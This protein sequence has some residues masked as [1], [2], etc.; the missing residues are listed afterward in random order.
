[1]S[2]NRNSRAIV[3][4]VQYACLHTL[5]VLQTSSDYLICALN[6]RMENLTIYTLFTD[7][8]LRRCATEIAPLAI[9]IRQVKA[10]QRLSDNDEQLGKSRP[11]PTPVDI[12]QPRRS[13]VET[14]VHL[15][16]KGCFRRK[17]SPNCRCSCRV[18]LSAIRPSI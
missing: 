8:F 6:Y 3:F 2:I 17:T 14:Q 1:M 4:P 16:R 15:F 5:S 7:V 18:T 12:N 13:A 10:T 11:L 9:T